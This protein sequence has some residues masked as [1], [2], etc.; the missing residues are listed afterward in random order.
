MEQVEGDAVGDGTSGFHEVG[1]E[2][3]AVADV[4]V[5]DAE[6]GVEPDVWAAIVASVSSTAY[7]AVRGCWWDP[8]PRRP[9]WGRRSASCPTRLLRE[10]RYREKPRRTG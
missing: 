4:G 9:Q 3:A 10:P 6:G 1:G 5:Q 7:P 8:E 2:R